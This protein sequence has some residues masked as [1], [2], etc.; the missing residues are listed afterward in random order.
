MVLWLAPAAIAMF[1]LQFF[2]WGLF[3]RRS[4]WDWIHCCNIRE[5]ERKL[6]IGSKWVLTAF[7]DVVAF[8]FLFLLALE[9]LICIAMSFPIAT[10]FVFWG[11]L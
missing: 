6:P 7:T 9:G 4:V 8:S 2:G 5:G 1:A 11:Q 3:Y 10:Q